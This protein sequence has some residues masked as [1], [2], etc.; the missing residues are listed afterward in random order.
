MRFGLLTQW[1]DPEPG[2]AALP[3]ALAR[4]LQKMGHDVSVL[5]GYPNYPTGAI[6]RGYRQRFGHSEQRDSVRVYRAPL[7]P[8]HDADMSR[9]LLNY[10]SFAAS[11]TATAC[12]TQFFKG[13][14]AVWVNYSPISI[15]VPL[16]FGQ[17]TQGTPAVVEVGDLWPDTVVA[18]G[19]A[20]RGLTGRSANNLMTWWCRHFYKS[21]ASVTYISP[22]VGAV[23]RE[24]GVPSEKLHYIPKWADESTFHTGGS[25]LRELYGVPD[26]YRVLLYAGALGEAQGID[27]LV[28]ACAEVTNLPIICLI[29]GSGTQEQCLR[30]LADEVGA[31]NVRFI[32]RVP[33]SQMTDLMAT[34]DFCYIGLRPHPLSAI[35]MP[36]KT[37]ATLAA[38][39]PIL[40]AASGDVV[41]VVESTRTG[42]AADPSDFRS[43]ASAIRQ[44]CC[45][46]TERLNEAS[47]TAQQI[48]Q[49]MFAESHG[50]EAIEN[51]LVRAAATKRSKRDGEE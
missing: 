20:T 25:S 43:I 1:Y 39:K 44:L 9:R 51:L 48:Y 40:V 37:Q 13:L 23:L 14:D 46:S 4:G 38:G 6:A 10:A 36:S 35:T 45:W 33:Q 31:H 34:A 15:A 22:G 41:D 3:G 8:S 30:R 47:T 42:I 16:W 29:A 7:Y 27:T 11:A 24:R 18:S 21:A 5:T 19:L 50:V 26:N 49:N 12:V 28:R 17:L 2:P 32:G